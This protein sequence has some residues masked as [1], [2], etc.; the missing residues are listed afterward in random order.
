[1]KDGKAHQNQNEIT[2]KLDDGRIANKLSASFD[3]SEEK[4]EGTF[5]V[6]ADDDADDRD[7]FSEA[8]ANSGTKVKMETARDGVELIELLKSK[9]KLPDLIFLD[10]NMPNKNGRDCLIEIRKS[11]EL[12]HIPVVIYSTSSSRIDI[13]FTYENGANLFVS[14]PSSFRELVQIAKTVLALDW[15]KY[16]PKSN[17]DQYVFSLK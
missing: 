12:R 7:L 2:N 1:M 5:I 3:E 13:D 10:L 15:K 14:K 11:A 4:T 9:N 8:V 16:Q 6:L 17:K